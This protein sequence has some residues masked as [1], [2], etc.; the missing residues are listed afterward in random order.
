MKLLQPRGQNRHFRKSG[1]KAATKRVCSQEEQRLW[2]MPAA[3]VGVL[4]GGV[5]LQLRGQRRAVAAAPQAAKPRAPSPGR[6]GHR[7]LGLER[8]PRAQPGFRRAR[9][10]GLQLHRP[11]SGPPAWIAT[12]GASSAAGMPRRLPPPRPPLFHRSANQRRREAASR[13]MPTKKRPPLQI[14]RASCRERV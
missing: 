11:R 4:C 3:A 7:G 10:L 14:G 2:T 6:P 8:R 1:A 12:V 9:R 5:G 13:K